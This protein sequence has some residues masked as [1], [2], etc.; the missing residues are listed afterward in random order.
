MDAVVAE[1][2]AVTAWKCTFTDA[3]RRLQTLTDADS[4]CGAFAPSACDRVNPYPG[5]TGPLK[6]DFCLK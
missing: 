2:D 6:I 5:V 3:Y 4:R 1:S